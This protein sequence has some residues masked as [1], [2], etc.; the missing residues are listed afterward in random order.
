MFRFTTKTD[1]DVLIEMA[2][3]VLQRNRQE[4]MLWKSMV[5]TPINSDSLDGYGGT[6]ADMKQQM[7]LMR[8]I[9]NLS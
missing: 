1:K 5:D 8:V 2:V 3:K 7:R 4:L 6:E 9:L